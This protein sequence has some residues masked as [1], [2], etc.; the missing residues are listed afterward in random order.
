MTDNDSDRINPTP[1]KDN[2]QRKN[3]RGVLL[4]LKK[5]I[6][7]Y[8]HRRRKA[9]SI[10]KGTIHCA[11]TLEFYFFI[12]IHNTIYEVRYTKYKIRGIRYGEIRISK[13]ACFERLAGKNI[14][15]RNHQGQC[16][17]AIRT[18]SACDADDNGRG[19]SRPVLH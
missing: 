19:A 1:T 17:L 5:C 18:Y 7:L 10:R 2:C 6:A 4:A 14:Q 13:I 9:S 15:L 11:P 8:A 16:N 3:S 12:A